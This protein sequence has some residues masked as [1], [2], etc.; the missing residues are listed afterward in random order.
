[1]SEVIVIGHNILSPNLIGKDAI[2]SPN[3]IGKDAIA[4]PNL[5]GKDAIAIGNG[6]GIGSASSVGTDSIVIGKG[7]VCSNTGSI[8]LGNTNSSA[9]NQL[10][11]GV[12]S[13]ILKTTL[14]TNTT[15]RNTLATYLP[16]VLKWNDILF[17]TLYDR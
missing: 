17:R 10:C 14:T 3:L 11:V 15:A 1:M 6:I 12:G 2:A 7:A 5:I 4:S 16:I 9:N 13:N 8:V